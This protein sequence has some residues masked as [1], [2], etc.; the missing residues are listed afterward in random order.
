[1]EQLVYLLEKHGDL[2]SLAEQLR[3]TEPVLAWERRRGEEEKILTRLA[4]YGESR[5]N[6]WAKQKEQLLDGLQE[7]ERRILLTRLEHISPPPGKETAV[8]LTAAQEF[9]RILEFPTQREYKSFRYQITRYLREQTPPPPP[10]TE[11]GAHWLEEHRQAERQGAAQAVAVLAAR[12]PAAWRQVFEGLSIFPAVDQERTRRES[13]AQAVETSA[14]PLYER[15]V[16]EL[17]HRKELPRGLVAQALPALRQTLPPPAQSTE[18]IVFTPQTVLQERIADTERRATQSFRQNLIARL[19]PG[20]ETVREIVGAA[21]QTAP[22]PGY[23]PSGDA[24]RQTAAQTIPVSG[25][26]PY[27]D[28]DR[29][30]VPLQTA[31]LYSTRSN[32]LR[33]AA[34]NTAFSAASA[35]S[36]P[37]EPAQ[38]SGRNDAFTQNIWTHHTTTQSVQQNLMAR[39]F[40]TR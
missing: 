37:Q 14:A 31:P 20:R 8:S 15:L 40:P 18:R 27:R 17:T 32:P 33:F 19:S 4:Q 6:G 7:S 25:Y 11:R 16:Q 34:G 26:R 3:T 9:D 13:L 22:S 5:G 10:L 2:P 38:N 12:R 30:T 39:L 21:A 36:I 24:D 28:A 35:V 29:Q 23:R 1:S